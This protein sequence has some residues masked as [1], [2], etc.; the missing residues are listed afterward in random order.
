MAGMFQIIT[1]LLCVYL[2]FK[3][4]EILQIALM[5][6]RASRRAGLVLGVLAVVASIVATIFFVHIVDA[7]ADS[8]AGP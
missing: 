1:Y 2:I 5:S 8:I 3:G 4:F 6:T 7:Q